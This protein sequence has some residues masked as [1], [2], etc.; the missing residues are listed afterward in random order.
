MGRRV[1]IM[2][3]CIACGCS[4]HSGVFNWGFGHGS[5]HEVYGFNQATKNLSNSHNDKLQKHE[6]QLQ[7]FASFLEI[8]HVSICFGILEYLLYQL[9]DLAAM[10]YC[11]YYVLRAPIV[12]SL[13]K[14]FSSFEAGFR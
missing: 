5:I 13:S 7:E 6:S 8:I 12:P 10:L 4:N 3:G 9:I 2:H 11:I 14:V 1:V